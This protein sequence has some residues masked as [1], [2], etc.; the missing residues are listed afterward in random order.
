MRIVKVLGMIAGILL[1]T[2]AVPV[3]L[4]LIGRSVIGILGLL[5]LLVVTLA[6]RW[7][8]R[9]DAVGSHSGFLRMHDRGAT[10]AHDRLLQDVDAMRG[11]THERAQQRHHD[12]D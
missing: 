2:I 8:R 11:R 4:G 7:F 1:L 10:Q 5:V 9:T 12:A 3:L 6:I